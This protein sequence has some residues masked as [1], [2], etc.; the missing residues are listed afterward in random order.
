MLMVVFRFSEFR[1]PAPRSTG[2]GAAESANLGT[3]RNHKS[4]FLGLRTL[5]AVGGVPHGHAHHALHSVGFCLQLMG[6]LSFVAFA[7]ACIGMLVGVLLLVE[8]LLWIRLLDAS[9]PFLG[10][11]CGA[12]PGVYDAHCPRIILTQWKVGRWGG[13]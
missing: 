13:Q 11:Y 2:G 12:K 1:V 4:P 9:T 7:G 5:H 3:P 10:E 6:G 8:S